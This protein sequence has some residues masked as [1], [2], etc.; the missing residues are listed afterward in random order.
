MSRLI[1]VILFSVFTFFNY[2]IIY[3]M[4]KEGNKISIS[5]IEEEEHHI[6]ILEVKHYLKKESPTIILFKS[7]EENSKKSYYI[8]FNKY[9]DV[10]LNTIDSPPDFMC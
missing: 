1:P 7:L 5:I 10:Y 3:N 8:N 4:H 9:E 2:A 6:K